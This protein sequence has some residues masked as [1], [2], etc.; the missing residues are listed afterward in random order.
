M[1][2]ER[3]HPVDDAENDHN[4]DI[5][6]D[7]DEEPEKANGSDH[8]GFPWRRAA[9]SGSFA[10]LSTHEEDDEYPDDKTERT[11]N[12]KDRRELK[13]STSFDMDD[14]DLDTLELSR[15][16]LDFN[17]SS[18][19]L[20]MP[21]TTLEESL[22]E[23]KITPQRIWQAWVEAREQTRRRRV[24]RMLA[25]NNDAERARLCLSSW[26]DLTDRGFHLLVGIMIVW[27][28]ICSLLHNALWIVWGVLIFVCR[29]LW[30][31]AYW[32]FR[33]RHIAR[34][35]K[36]TMEIYDEVNRVHIEGPAVDDEEDESP[37]TSDVERKKIELI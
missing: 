1:S 12:R 7:S 18:A 27:I 24:E 35:R 10:R 31:P 20:R 25:I 23:G 19:R 37:E 32:Y 34:K 29:V 5:N 11:S 33:G 28:A 21:S 13:I 14:D 36:Q 6:H 2:D 4:G 26:C 17:N 15:Y 30:P 22:E 3:Y 8:Q 16:R 9:S